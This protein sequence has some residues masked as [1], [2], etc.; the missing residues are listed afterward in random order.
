MADETSGA[1]DDRRLDYERLEDFPRQLAQHSYLD[2][3]LTG[4]NAT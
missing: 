2:L 3:T 4:T 1:T